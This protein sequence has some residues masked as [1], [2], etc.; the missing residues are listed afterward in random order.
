MVAGNIGDI[1]NRLDAAGS[2]EYRIDYENGLA[3]VFFN[4]ADERRCLEV[5]RVSNFYGR[6]PGKGK[7]AVL[8][9]RL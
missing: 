5:D 3:Y 4:P 1:A 9:E 7:E 8:L 6:I 2:S